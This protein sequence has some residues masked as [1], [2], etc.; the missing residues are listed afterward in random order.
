MDLDETLPNIEIDV[1]QIQQLLVN[2]L[3]N[4]VESTEEKALLNK[5]DDNTY[6]K[7]ISIKT[8]YNQSLK[9]VTIE[10]T[11]NGCG[12]DDQTLGKIFNLHFTTKK[13]GHGL[14]LYNSQRIVKQHRGQ[15]SAD[16]VLNESTT[17]YITLPRFQKKKES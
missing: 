4:A 11:D 9:N 17:I 13:N 1:A 12:M 2:I 7:N 5:V 10:I 8:E 16:S 14:G 3:N 6:Q 15:I